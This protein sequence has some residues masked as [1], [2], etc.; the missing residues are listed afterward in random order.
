MHSVLSILNLLLENLQFKFSD[1]GKQIRPSDSK[2]NRSQTNLL[3][4]QIKYIEQLF[5]GQFPYSLAENFEYTVADSKKT[6]ANT[7]LKANTINLLLCKLCSSS[8]LQL[9]EQRLLGI[10][11]YSLDSLVVTN[12]ANQYA[13]NNDS[14]QH[15]LELNELATLLNLAETILSSFSNIGKQN[16][17]ITI[18]IPLVKMIPI[19]DTFGKDGAYY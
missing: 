2:Q 8:L 9:T 16:L 13:E 5:L 19:I 3:Q 1:L 6:P 15:K 18:L 12:K 11:K 4:H 7:K 10:F 14:S 17:V